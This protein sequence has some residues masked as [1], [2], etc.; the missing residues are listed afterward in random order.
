MFGKFLPRSTTGKGINIF[1]FF[2]LLFLSLYLLLKYHEGSTHTIWACGFSFKNTT[3]VN[4]SHC[5]F[6]FSI[7]FPLGAHSHS[8][9]CLLTETLLFWQ[10]CPWIGSKESV[11]CLFH[12]KMQSL[13]FTTSLLALHI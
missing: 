13:W 3:K 10:C 8:P 1:Q 12:I 4:Y 7:R 2:I 11:F 6:K 9:S 5:P